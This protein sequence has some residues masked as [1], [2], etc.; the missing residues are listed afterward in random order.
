[1][2]NP[3][4]RIGVGYDAQTH[5]IVVLFG[6]PIDHLR[7]SPDQA[8]AIAQELMNQVKLARRQQRN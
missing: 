8:A 1:M 5:S 4:E 3:P 2:N 6:Q 7:L